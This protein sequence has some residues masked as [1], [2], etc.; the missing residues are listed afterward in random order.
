ILFWVRAQAGASEVI[1]LCLLY[2]KAF[3]VSFPP[4]DSR[5]CKPII[6]H[7]KIKNDKRNRCIGGMLF[8]FATFDDDVNAIVHIRYG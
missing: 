5:Q 8:I 1:G 7:R 2:R 6:N 3:R 4:V